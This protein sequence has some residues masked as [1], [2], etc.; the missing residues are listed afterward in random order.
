MFFLRLRTSFILYIYKVKRHSF[1]ILHEYLF[2]NEEANWGNLSLVFCSEDYNKIWLLKDQHE[3]YGQRICTDT[4]LLLPVSNMVYI[5]TGYFLICCIN[6]REKSRTKVIW[7][8]LCFLSAA[9]IVSLCLF[10]CTSLCFFGT[11]F[12]CIVLYDFHRPSYHRIRFVS[13]MC[14]MVNFDS[15]FHGSNLVAFE[16]LTGFVLSSSLLPNIMHLFHDYDHNGRKLTI[17]CNVVSC[18]IVIL[19]C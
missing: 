12:L 8:S 18:V 9:R 15:F 13:Y 19:L 4:W 17:I 6:A 10:F 16:F 7:V 3:G 14:I 2:F 1:L 5:C 11:M